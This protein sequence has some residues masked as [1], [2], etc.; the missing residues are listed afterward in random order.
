[1]DVD[2]T[3]LLETMKCLETRHVNPPTD[4]ENVKVSKKA[5]PGGGGGAI[6]GSP[7]KTA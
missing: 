5:T 7:A 4:S 2:Q 6:M 3:N 1:M